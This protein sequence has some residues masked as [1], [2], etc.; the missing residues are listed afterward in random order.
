MAQR[1]VQ[2]LWALFADQMALLGAK[3]RSVLG[4]LTAETPAALT[5]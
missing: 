5:R 3:T 1:G 2:T 4:D